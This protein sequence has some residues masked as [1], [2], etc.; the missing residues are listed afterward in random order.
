MK[1]RV[2][3]NLDNIFEKFLLFR[4]LRDFNVSIL[5][6][7]ATIINFKLYHDYGIR[8]NVHIHIYLEELI[9]FSNLFK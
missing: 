8:Q 3:I 1:K 5:N 7:V 6:V 2:L 9:C 4:N